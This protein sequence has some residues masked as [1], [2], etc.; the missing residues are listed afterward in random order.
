MTY[1]DRESRPKNLRTMRQRVEAAIK[2]RLKPGQVEK[3]VNDIATRYIRDSVETVISIAFGFDRR[4]GKE[5]EL[6]RG[7]EKG[8]IAAML[9]EMLVSDEVQAFVREAI[10]DFRK[11]MPATTL[12]MWR[13]TYKDYFLRAYWERAD[14]LIQTHAT[15]FGYWRAEEDYRERLRALTYDVLDLP[16]DHPARTETEDNNT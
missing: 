12:A 2:D 11:L 8:A 4:W 7:F 3:E 14:E 5:F 15:E 16:K 10:G 1:G 9:Q 13:K 6:H